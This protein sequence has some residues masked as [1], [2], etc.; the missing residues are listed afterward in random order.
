VGITTLPD[1]L[2]EDMV[3][4]TSFLLALYH[5]LLHVHVVNGI[6]KCPITEK[7]FIIQDEIPNMIIEETECERVRY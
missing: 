7:Q 5:I 6:L 3:Q 4:D 2:T 1:Q